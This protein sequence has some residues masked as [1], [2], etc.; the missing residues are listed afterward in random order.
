MDN[1]KKRQIGGALKCQFITCW[2]IFSIHFIYIG[3]FHGIFQKNICVLDISIDIVLLF[4]IES[5]SVLV[6]LSNIRNNIKFFTIAIIISAINVILNLFYI[7]VVVYFIFMKKEKGII[8]PELWPI[9]QANPLHGTILIVIKIIEMIPLLVLIV[10]KIKIE[11][12]V[13]T[14]NPENIAGLILDKNNKEDDDDLD[15]GDRDG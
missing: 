9:Y 8:E 6:T 1:S 13:G 5:I 10:A 15:D 2:I 4:T 12:S 7:F 3:I 11:S 14:I